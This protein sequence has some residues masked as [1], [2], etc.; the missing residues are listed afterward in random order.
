M[1]TGRSFSLTDPELGNMSLRDD[2]LQ[3]FTAS[4]EYRQGFVEEKIRTGLAA[5]IKAVRERW[6]GGMKQADF[7]Q[8][9]GKSQS[10]VSRL[11]DPNAPIPTVPTLLLVARTFDIGLKVCFVPFSELLDDMASLSPDA[12][13]VPTFKEDL[14]LFPRK[15]PRM[16]IHRAPV[17]EFPKDS[18]R[19]S[20]GDTEAHIPG[21]IVGDVYL[22]DEG[23]LVQN[24]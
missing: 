18:S 5:Q 3:N 4:E 8:R 16:E 9:L 1:Q 20:I 22:R 14:H 6:Q 12:L 2:L 13:Y 11:E 23:R 17:L 7:A 19:V 15:G 21:T 24:G 10:W